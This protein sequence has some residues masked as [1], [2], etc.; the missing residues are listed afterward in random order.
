MLCSQSLSLIVMSYVTSVSRVRTRVRFVSLLIAA[1]QQGAQPPWVIHFLRLLKQLVELEVLGNKLLLYA[2]YPSILRCGLPWP[3]ALI[4][5]AFQRCG[6]INIVQSESKK[7]QIH[8]ILNL[9][10]MAFYCNRCGMWHVVF[11]INIHRPIIS[12]LYQYPIVY[13]FSIQSI[14]HDS[15]EI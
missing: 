6:L 5:R 11:Y 9:K 3:I 7:N 1:S 14:Y 13:T 10:W 4:K 8:L 12:C 15:H 2:L